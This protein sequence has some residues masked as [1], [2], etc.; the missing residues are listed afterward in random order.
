MDGVDAAVIHAVKLSR[1]VWRS[2]D[3][4]EQQVSEIVASGAS[5]EAGCNTEATAPLHDVNGM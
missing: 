4:G 5:L 2:G 1:E 3:R